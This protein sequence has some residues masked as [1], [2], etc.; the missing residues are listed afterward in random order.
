MAR[1]RGQHHQNIQFFKLEDY[2]TEFIVFADVVGDMLIKKGKA[3]DFKR[4]L[5]KV[6][7]SKGAVKYHGMKTNL[8]AVKEPKKTGLR[9]G[10]GGKEPARTT[11]ELALEQ[12]E[13]KFQINKEDAI[14]INEICKEVSNIYE[15]K[16]RV[17]ANKDN[18]NYLKTSAEPRVKQEVKGKYIER[19]LINKLED[20]LY[21][22]RGGIISLMGKAIIQSIISMTG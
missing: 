15:I 10:G 17:L 21:S 2:L 8:H 9:L 6:E 1:M 16:E 3:S 18:E 4:F 5:E 12:I 20:P 7:L 19:D 22:Q 14:V 11:I 13:E